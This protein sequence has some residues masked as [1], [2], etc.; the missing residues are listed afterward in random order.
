M[1][2]YLA[3]I[4]L[5]IWFYRLIFAAALGPGI[6]PFTVWADT[7]N[8]SASANVAPFVPLSR[9]SD[10]ILA[11]DQK[12]LAALYSQTPPSQTQAPEG[13]TDDPAEEPAFWSL[14]RGKGLTHINLKVLEIQKP[15][16]GIVTVVL[17]AELTIHTIAG[18][19]PF[20]VEASQAWGQGNDGVWRIYAT[21]RDDVSPNPPR[22]LTEPAK[23]NTDLYVP[24]EDAKPEI[25]AALAMAAKDHKRLIL[26]FGANWCYDCHVLDATFHSKQ[27]APLVQANF[28]VVHVN[29]CEY[30]CNLDLV[31][32]YEIPIKKGVPS[33]AVL[34]S[35]GKL[36]YSQQKGEFENSVRIGPDDVTQFLDK[37]KPAR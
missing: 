14:L 28:H 25:A 32:K 35:D 27:M 3:G 22:R 2:K 16:T 8:A 17:R 11:G 34:D 33:L 29:I 19:Q 9:W 18:D 10:A 6:N 37:W 13:K 5:S 7:K 26:V 20:V 31:E 23:P 1:K 12:S 30:D 4:S 24:A 36:L 15:K 21:T